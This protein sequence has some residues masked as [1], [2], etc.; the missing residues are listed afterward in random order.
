MTI[1]G[2]LSF[3]ALVFVWVAAIDCNFFNISFATTQ[4]HDGYVRVGLWTVQSYFVDYSGDDTWGS[5]C[6]GWENA[7]ILSYYDLDGAMKTARAF[8]MIS[9]VL[10]SISFILILVPMCVSFGDHQQYLLILCGMCVFTG[11]AAILDLVRTECA[12]RC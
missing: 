2:L 8:S 7:N 9:A 4:G 6:A 5:Y 12:C 10:G 11:F 3:I 1:P